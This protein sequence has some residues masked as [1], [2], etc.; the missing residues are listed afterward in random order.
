M[1][2]ANATCAVIPPEIL[3]FLA[4]PGRV[5]LIKGSAGAG[6]TLLA[7]ELARAYQAQ[8]GDVIWASSR[9]AD[10]AEAID[11]EELAPAQHLN[12]GRAAPK[13]SEPLPSTPL[14]DEPDLLTDLERDLD[15][16][17]SL[18]IVDSIDGLVEEG[19]VDG[20]NDF[21]VRAKSMAVRMGVRFA[22]TLESADPHALDY[23]ADGVVVLEQS[24][25]DGARIRTLHVQ[26][27]RGTQIAR[28]VY[29]FTLAGGVFT[30][31]LDE[32][33]E[34]VAKPLRVPGHHRKDGFLSTG[35]HALDTMLGGGFREGS[36]HL[37][38]FTADAAVDVGR[39][40]N[41]L[42]LN[43]LALG[44]TAIW[45][46]M[47]NAERRGQRHLAL[48]HVDKAAS[49]RLALLQASDLDGTGSVRERLAPLERARRILDPAVT[50]LSLDLLRL[51]ADGEGHAWLKRWC[52]RT[53][54]TRSID[55]LI[56][57]AGRHEVAAVADDQWRL[58]R[59]HDVPILRGTVPP[60]EHHFL[61]TRTHKGYPET[62]L[63]AI[64]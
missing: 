4:R 44:K 52:E 46:A 61:R 34:A 37:V 39:L 30:V 21:M 18:V 22:V 20:A 47:P 17:D 56:A 42:I 53:R 58:T 35:I 38:E 49:E 19:A 59:L 15:Q 60:T 50:I 24:I 32:P 41:P 29:G 64:Q 54:A 63:E 9:Q 5:L 2:W 1:G 14:A 11:L 8:G 31:L 27:M 3:P 40:T 36:V 26:K 55:V 13:A 45:A 6:K 23:L 12:V 62:L 25:L 48:Q 16:A 57:A 43:T 51:P 33:G 28:P 10:P 7:M